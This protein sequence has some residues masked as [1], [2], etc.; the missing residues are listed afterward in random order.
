MS[1]I[2][3]SIKPKLVEQKVFDKVMKVQEETKPF[4][5][6]FNI[7]PV[8]YPILKQHILSISIILGIILLLLYRYYD[9]KERK[10]KYNQSNQSNQIIQKIDSYSDEE[11]FDNSYSE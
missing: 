7:L 9:V 10:K 11:D 3:G 8:I 5:I 1:F 2:D 6:N 4:K